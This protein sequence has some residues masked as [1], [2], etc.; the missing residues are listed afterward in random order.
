MSLPTSP[1]PHPRPHTPPPIWIILLFL[2]FLYA[3][4]HGHTTLAFIILSLLIAIRTLCIPSNQSKPGY[5]LDTPPPIPP[6]TPHSS[7]TR[8]R[9]K[10]RFKGELNREE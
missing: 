5:K 9:K 1:P 7:M 10:G 3:L 8:S 6:F 2:A 4:D